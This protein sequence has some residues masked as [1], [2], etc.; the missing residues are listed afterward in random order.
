MENNED[1]NL[2]PLPDIIDDGQETGK[3]IIGLPKGSVG[4]VITPTRNNEGYGVNVVANFN[5]DLPVTISQAIWGLIKG[6]L[7]AIKYKKESLYRLAIIETRKERATEI[8]ADDVTWNKDT[9]KHYLAEAGV[10]G[11]A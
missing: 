2:A 6:C 8:N 7:A 5:P 9:P 1:P 10:K 11:N 3:V 4:L